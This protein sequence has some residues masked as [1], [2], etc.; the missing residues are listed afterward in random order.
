MADRFERL[1]NLVATLLDTRRA[2]TLDE[3]LD[4]VPGYPDE[5]ESARRQFERDKESLR[6]IGVPIDLAE[7]AFG[8]FV[9]YRVHPKEY[10][11]PELDLTAEERAAL[12]TAVSAMRVEGGE[13]REA[14]WKLGGVDGDESPVL[15]ALPGVPALPV[16]MDACRRRVPLGFTHRGRARRLHPYA[17]VFHGGNW[18]VIGHDLDRDEVRSFRTDRIEGDL[19][20][21]PPGAFERPAGFDPRT[22][23]HDEPWRYGDEPAIEAS[24]RVDAV[25]ATWVIRRLGDH[26][27]LERGDDGSATVRLTVTNREAFRSFVLGLLDHSVVLEPPGLREEVV[28]WLREISGKAS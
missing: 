27:V 21:G 18:Y 8:E 12:H 16:F 5:K 22:V 6:G 20:A 4:R 7:D 24:V 28:G 9:G 17:V 10:E 11:L 15:G 13:G 25:V 14:L 1:T 2:L 23:L 26:A 19:A 3:I